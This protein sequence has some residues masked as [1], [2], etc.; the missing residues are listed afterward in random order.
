MALRFKLRQLE[1]FLALAETLNFREAAARLHMTQ[2]PLSRQ[3]QELEAALGAQLLHRSSQGVTLTGSGE[4][5]AKEAVRL[6]QDCEKLGQRFAGQ[7]TQRLRIGLTT[8]VETEKFTQLPQ[9]DIDFKRQTSVKSVRDLQQEKLD[10]AIIGMPTKT[11]GLTVR[12]LYRDR[13]CV[14]LPKGHRLAARKAISLL[15]LNDSKLFWFR[16]DRNPGFYDACEALFKKLHFA[17]QRLPEPTDHHV[18]LSRIANEDGI[19][20]VPESLK[21][22]RHHGVVFRKLKEDELLFIDIGIAHRPDPVR[23]LM[24]PLIQQLKTLFAS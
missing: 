8:V 16:R 11:D 4:L 2:P 17:P 1:M 10:A 5:L 23:P 18:L 19:G 24:Q 21:K 12:H 6:L 13:L 15:D 9:W 14:A 3:M 22:I 20:L 7:P